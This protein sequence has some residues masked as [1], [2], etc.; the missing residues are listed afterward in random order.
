MVR[1]IVHTAFLKPFS[2]MRATAGSIALH[3]LVA[4]WFLSS[5]PSVEIMPQQMIEVTLIAAPSS[6][7]PVTQ[8]PSPTLKPTAKKS[9]ET[10]RKIT[11]PP[12]A[13]AAPAATS[14]RPTPAA[15]QPA[16]TSATAQMTITKPLFDNAYLNNPAPE[17]PAHAR[18]RNMEGTVILDVM[19]SAEGIA[20]YVRI[21]ESSGFS[22]L[23]ESAKNAVSR[24]KFVP[25]RRG[26]DIVEARVIV[27]IE[28]RLE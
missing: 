19:V 9:P 25:A 21:A 3:L 14:A 6:P 7:E 1:Y 26:S 28:F 2:G 20:H 17:Y 10:T 16:S 23:D 27:P 8:K 24:W 4:L 22:L 15:G 18:R 12:P 11:P 5:T 13:Q